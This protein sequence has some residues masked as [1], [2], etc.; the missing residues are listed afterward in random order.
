MLKIIFYSISFYILFHSIYLFVA[1]LIA[2]KSRAINYQFTNYKKRILIVIPA[3]KEDSVIC[4]TV[5]QLLNN[6]YKNKL[7]CVVG[8]QLKYETID[9]LISKEIIFLKIWGSE[10]NSH[11]WIFWIHGT[12]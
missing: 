2:K 8:Y 3:Y 7:I 12:F 6:P 4:N 11:I 1:A 5:T 10:P 9:F